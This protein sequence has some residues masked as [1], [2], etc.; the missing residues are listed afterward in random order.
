MENLDPS[1]LY[2]GWVG[3]LWGKNGHGP[4]SGSTWRPGEAVS[5]L[6]KGKTHCYSSKSCLLSMGG[7]RSRPYV[8]S[9]KG[10]LLNVDQGK[11]RRKRFPRVEPKGARHAKRRGG[12]KAV[13]EMREPWRWKIQHTGSLFPASWDQV[14]MTEVWC[15]GSCTLQLFRSCLS[16]ETDLGEKW[17]FAERWSAASEVQ[18]YWGAA[19]EVQ[20]SCQLGRKVL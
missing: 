2:E 6:K 18:K 9:L 5:S 7:S 3:P 14:C 19:S 11:G 12:K 10:W 15:G 13:E 16:L 8:Y 20:K 1:A 4:V 17:S